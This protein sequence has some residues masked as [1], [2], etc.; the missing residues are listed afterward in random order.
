MSAP[1]PRTLDHF[2]FDITDGGVVL[3]FGADEVLDFT[4]DSDDPDEIQANIKTVR[5]ILASLRLG[6]V[7][8]DILEG[9]DDLAAETGRTCE[10]CHGEREIPSGPDT[11]AL[12]GWCQGTGW[13]LP[14]AIAA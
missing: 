3:R 2:D 12:C 6:A 8:L 14:A 11:S 9:L 13:I 1:T 5:G 4:I 7:L 10:S